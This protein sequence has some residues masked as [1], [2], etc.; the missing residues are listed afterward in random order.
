[1][2]SKNGDGG[3]SEAI[4][5]RAYPYT[6]GKCVSQ[7]DIERT[8][9]AHIRRSRRLWM[10]APQYRL[11]QVPVGLGI[12]PLKDRGQVPS[13]TGD[14]LRGHDEKE[15]QGNVIPAQAGIQFYAPYL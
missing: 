4:R 2:E 3:E 5:G 11:G 14:R 8:V 10:P 9:P 13:R 1:A 12:N 7:G 15:S 6:S